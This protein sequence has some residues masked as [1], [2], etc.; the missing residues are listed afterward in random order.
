[1]SAN[2][3]HYFL[4]IGGGKDS[5]LLIQK[6]K[7]LGKSVLLVDRDAQAPGVAHADVYLQ[8]STY[9]VEPIIQELNA[10]NWNEGKL[11]G[12]VTRSSGVPV[13]TTARLAEHFNLPGGGVY[14]AETLTRKDSFTAHLKKHGLPN[15]DSTLLSKDHYYEQIRSQIPCVVK[16]TLGVVGKLGVELITSEEQIEKSVANAKKASTTNE[17]LLET[18][19]TGEDISLLSIVFANQVYPVMFLTE[20]NHFQV[21]G[22]VQCDGFQINKELDESDSNRMIHLAQQ[23]TS[24]S[25][26]ASSPLL[27]SFRLQKGQKAVPIEANLDFGGEQVLEDFQNSL[28]VPDF[29]GLYLKAIISNQKPEIK[30]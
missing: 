18:F 26:L 20:K 9:E 4:V 7:A 21:D 25:K 16:P 2:M 15:A 6:L 11:A 28:E 8:L 14:A 17:L 10:F 5:V 12:I 19:I 30:N 23:I 13:I 1:M 29:I 24:T 3:S 22:R 27:L